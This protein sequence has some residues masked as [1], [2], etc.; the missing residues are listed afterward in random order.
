MPDART[1]VPGV[2]PAVRGRVHERGKG[3][4]ATGSRALPSAWLWTA[5]SRVVAELALG[6][7]Q[8]E[9]G[10]PDPEDQDHGRPAEE[11]VSRC[12]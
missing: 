2:A 5:F 11:W 9:K 4:G 10:S 6:G 12:G 3:C 1:E 7:T 8:K